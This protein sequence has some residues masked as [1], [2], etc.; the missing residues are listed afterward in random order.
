MMENNSI[1]T[2]RDIDIDMRE[3]ARNNPDIY[4]HIF[5]IFVEY[6]AESLGLGIVNYDALREAA[7]KIMSIRCYINMDGDREITADVTNADFSGN[8]AIYHKGDEEYDMYDILG[9]AYIAD[10]QML[11]NGWEKNGN[12]I[13]AYKYI[14]D[15][16]GLEIRN[17]E[18]V[19]KLISGEAS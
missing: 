15:K 10:M 11:E 1:N 9:F 12:S 13:E 5:N 19:E 4:E 2:T 18:L 16:A 14:V 6:G 17:F 3:L 8:T 7:S